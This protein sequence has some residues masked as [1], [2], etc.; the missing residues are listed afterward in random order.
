M[1]DLIMEKVI[2]ERP[3]IEAI[4]ALRGIACIAIMLSHTKFKYLVGTGAWGVSI[5]FVLSGF[6]MI[7]SYYGKNRIKNTSIIENFIFAWKKIKKLYPLHIVA[8][9][10][11]AIFLFVGHDRV[12]FIQA[13]MKLITNF[14]LIQEWAPLRDRSINGVSWY[15]S[16]IL[17]CYFIFPWALWVFE[18]KIDRRSAKRSIV[19]LFVLM[20]IVG[21][22]GSMLRPFDD[23]T[24]KLWTTE[25]CS[26]FVYKFPVSRS[27]DFLIGCNIGY[28]FLTNS[29]SNDN[30]FYSHEK[31]I[32]IIACLFAVVS[33]ILFCL[34][35]YSQ[36][37]LSDNNNSDSSRWWTFVIAYIPSACLLVY[38]FAHNNSVLSKFLSNKV[39]L[40][41]GNV[42]QFVFLIHAV[43][44]DLIDPIIW[45]LF[46]KEFFDSYGPLIKISFG[47]A[48]TFISTDIWK[49]LNRVF[50]KRKLKN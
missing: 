29:D 43:I 1:K 38:I 31:I 6:M 40:Y 37:T 5:F 3:R 35:L 23:D 22:I 9:L 12:P 30:Y 49:L 39:L 24:N 15:L 11:L 8:T 14:L 41:I 34:M 36:K 45:K 47:I 48:L 4:Q 42:S 50:D 20:L 46:G 26:W 21:I 27:I 32:S 18:K 13:V 44:F 7:Y 19:I 25:L 33:N 2:N 28:L 16:S 17:F 10:I